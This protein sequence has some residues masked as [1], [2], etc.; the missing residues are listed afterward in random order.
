MEFGTDPVLATLPFLE[1]SQCLKTRKNWHIL[2]HKLLLILLLYILL[3][4]FLI[5]GHKFISVLLTI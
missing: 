1:I 3:V 4:I 2:T 5:E